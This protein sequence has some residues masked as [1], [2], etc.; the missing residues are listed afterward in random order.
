ML[1][2]HV[3]DDQ[4]ASESCLILWMH[5]A[6]ASLL[7]LPTP[8]TL[9][10]RKVLH[11]VYKRKTHFHLRLLSTMTSCWVQN[12]RC[13]EV[14]F[15][16]CVQGIRQLFFWL[17]LTLQHHGVSVFTSP[18]MSLTKQCICP[19]NVMQPRAIPPGYQQPVSLLQSRNIMILQKHVFHIGCFVRDIILGKGSFI[20]KQK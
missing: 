19:S 15:T 1:C 9:S 12:T 3:Y 18:S 2:I 16:E 14:A 5:Y 13:R 4:Q 20:W 6:T 11:S 10:Y 17:F 8:S 7:H